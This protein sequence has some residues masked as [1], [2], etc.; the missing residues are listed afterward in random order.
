[1]SENGKLDPAD[2]LPGPTGEPSTPI[3]ET[4]WAGLEPLDG[5]HGISRDSHSRHHVVLSA[6][7]LET[8]LPSLYR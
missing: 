5:E 8:A 7:P 6:D 3:T 1:M 4:L 2:R